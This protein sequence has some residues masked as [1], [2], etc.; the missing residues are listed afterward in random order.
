MT[1]RMTKLDNLLLAATMAEAGLP[2]TAREILEQD[3]FSTAKTIV[4][5]PAS[6]EI[7]SPPSLAAAQLVR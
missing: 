3:D 4:Q 6:M 5:K 1:T 2:D 7:A